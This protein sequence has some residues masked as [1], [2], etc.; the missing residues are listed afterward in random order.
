MSNPIL[1]RRLLLADDDFE[2]R[3][4]IA[5]FLGGPELEV[6]QAESGLEALEIVRD[7][8]IHAA[9]LDLHMPG[10]TGFEAL[11]RIQREVEGLPCIVYSGNLTEVL[12]RSLL[13]AGA[14]A[15]LRKPVEPGLLRQEVYRALELSPYQ[16][17]QPGRPGP[18]PELN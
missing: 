5:D 10:C 3:R 16:P 8:R 11:P 15:V 2:V 17:G 12:E 4:G 9:L 18:A 7:R 1:V 13:E 6:L 14:W